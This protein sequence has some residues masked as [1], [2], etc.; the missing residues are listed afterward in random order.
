M[1][2]RLKK[3]INNRRWWIVAI[4]TFILLLIFQIVFNKYEV[5]LRSLP[6]ELGAIAVAAKLS[7][8]DW[9]YVLS[10]ANMYYG[11]GM[12]IIFTPLFYLIDD[13]LL[14]Y[15]WLLAGG[16]VL[17]TIPVFICFSIIKKY[18]TD[19]DAVEACLISSIAIIGA[20]TRATNID[21]EPMLILI[22]WLILYL[23]FELQATDDNK[24]RGKYSV[25]LGIVLAYSLTVHSRAYIYLVSVLF[26]AIL[27]QV[28]NKKKFISYIPFFIVYVVCF[29]IGNLLKS[30]VQDLVYISNKYVNETVNNTVAQVSGSVLNNLQTTFFSG[31]GIKNFISLIFSNIWI[32]FT[33]YHGVVIFTIILV[34][35]LIGKCFLKKSNKKVGETENILL[36]PAIFA[37]S[38]F[39]I[40]IIG[41]G[42]LWIWSADEV[43]NNK[44]ELSR[45]YFYLRYIGNTFGPI[46]FC[47]LILMRKD[48]KKRGVLLALL[49]QSISFK[50]TVSNSLEVSLSNGNFHGDWFGYFAPFSFS[51]AGFGDG[52]D[53]ISYYLYPT[54]ISC[55]AFVVIIFLANK[56]NFRFCYSLIL[57]LLIYQYGYSV[58]KWDGPFSTGENYYGAVNGIYKLIKTDCG[59]FE[60][61]DNIYYCNNRF[62]PQFEVQFLLR[63]ICIISDIPE[64]YYRDMVILT[65]DI[66]YVEDNIN[67]S[68]T[69]FRIFQLDDNE[70]M[71]VNNVNR[72]KLLE[73]LQEVA[74]QDE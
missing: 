23:I 58:V 26:V 47:G 64:E 32:T 45:G 17:R 38:I 24:K 22:A 51:G 13:P 72:I 71:L 60:D 1:R 4:V 31:E 61:V 19:I 49:I 74:L 69:D 7:G 35:G 6:D 39:V 18:L 21:N 20:P 33:Y 3:Y 8:C 50:Y 46:L 54:F 42:I 30:N 57:S 25:I 70:F 15:Q 29:I 59:V 28:K 16:A 34:L 37:A 65:N 43:I 56:R 44:G 40:S 11:F 5:L 12:G 68:I 9:S 63:D 52:I 27:Y 55:I 62:G 53:N 2:D 14:L 67:F 36:F 41:L 66:M 10:Q 48:N 73:Q